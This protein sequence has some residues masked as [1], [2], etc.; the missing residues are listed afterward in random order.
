M[1][2]IKKQGIAMSTKIRALG[3]ALLAAPLLL[4]TASP[5]VAATPSAG[6]YAESYGLLVDTT[7]LAGNV[8]VKIGPEV[9]ISSSCPPGG[10][11]SGQLIDVPADPLAHA[12]VITDTATSACAPA[13]G[14]GV[15]NIVNV[16]VLK[17]QP[18]AIHADAV[19]STSTTT[20]DK[21]PKGSTEI[22][23]LSVGGQK[24]P[25]PS[26]PIPANTD[27]LPQLFEPL[28]L[29]VLLNEQHPA[30][31]GRGLVVNAIHVIASGTGA[32]PVG[33]T[34]IRGDIVVAHAVSG[35][36]CPGGP[37]SDNGGLPKP[38]ISFSK[39]A[40]PSTATA[41][42]TVTYTATVKN[43][44]TTA[45]EVL[46]FVDHIAPAFTLVSTAGALGT[47][48]DT[49]PPARTDGGVDAVLHPTGVTIGA[50]KS[51]TQT[52][53]VKVK[54]DATPGTY[55]NTLEI[56][57]GPNGNFVSG[58][59]APVTVPAPGV[60]V[61][62][63]PGGPVE[64]PPTQPVFAPTGLNTAVAGLSLLLLL[65]AVGTRRLQL[66]RR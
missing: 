44:S 16:D 65:A 38:A 37:G 58:P 6:A 36:V 56:F 14:K 19:T 18:V 39:S 41:G 24:I 34:V 66:S 40:S 49:P 64:Q 8:P 33:G 15:S 45:C 10:T 51:V 61:V 55:Y 46:R 63:P 35:V 5:A 4:G 32:L 42:S 25:I 57:C 17:G 11:K 43:Q 30:S 52:F 13:S 27:L 9:P 53:T 47:K 12:D 54:D 1:S 29:K 50:G 28:G 20:C 31:E 21:A 2:D 7:L 22:V 59:L 60:P 3:A 62:T 48:F 23:N 26:E